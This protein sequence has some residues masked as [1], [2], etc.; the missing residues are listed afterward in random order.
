MMNRMLGKQLGHY[1][2]FSGSVP[3]S[4]PGSEKPRLFRLLPHPE[5]SQAGAQGL[6]R[7]R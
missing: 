7:E 2:R 1:L 4:C 3:R 5:S 6:G